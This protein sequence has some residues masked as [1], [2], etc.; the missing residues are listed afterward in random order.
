MV[1]QR[2]TKPAM[3][4]RSIRRRREREFR[5]LVR[6]HPI[7]KVLRDDAEIAKHQTIIEEVLW[8][9]YGAGVHDSLKLSVLI[10]HDIMKKQ[11]S[12]P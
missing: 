11:Y 1:Y 10:V 12:L 4:L 6:Q 5:K 8:D 2:K 3:D 9:F 7:L